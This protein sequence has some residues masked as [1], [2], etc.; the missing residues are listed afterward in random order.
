MHSRF[1]HYGF[2]LVLLS[3][4]FTFAC[5]KKSEEGLETA[6]AVTRTSFAATAKSVEP[7]MPITVAHVFERSCQA[8][9]GPA[10]QG[11]AAVAP[12]LR[13][14]A[15][16]TVEQWTAY[17]THEHPGATLS[18]PTWINADEINVI[19][20][21]LANLKNADNVAPAAEAD[22]GAR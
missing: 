14:A 15:A 5:H 7:V 4:S 18:P 1:I 13:K 12:D 3:L 9:H 21:Y 20:G 8:C 10:G 2:L 11:I 22:K 17:L 19:A 6:E 16:R